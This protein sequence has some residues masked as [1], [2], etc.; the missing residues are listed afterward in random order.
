[1]RITI[2]LTEEERGAVAI[3]EAKAG[4]PRAAPPE[5]AVDA[6]P[7]PEALLLALGAPAAEAV[8]PGAASRE[9]AGAPPA[10]LVD[11]ITGGAAG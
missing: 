7:P 4:E 10:W 11:V 1:M 3:H 6:G 5:A 8:R 2:E 9:D